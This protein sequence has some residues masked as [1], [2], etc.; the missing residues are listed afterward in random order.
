L[1]LRARET[2]EIEVSPLRLGEDAMSQA[3]HV[4]DLP[5][6]VLVWEAS[7]ISATC[8]RARARREEI[9]PKEDGEA[10]RPRPCMK[11]HANEQTT[12]Q[13]KIGEREQV[14]R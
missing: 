9:R 4:W 2:R 13:E 6:R 12:K 11:A 7:G 14:V 8:A 1:V 3:G 5:T 10:R